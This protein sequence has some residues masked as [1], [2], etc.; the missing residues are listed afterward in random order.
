MKDKERQEI[1]LFRYSVL[2]PLIS[3]TYDASKSLASVL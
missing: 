2:A 1:A 3:Q